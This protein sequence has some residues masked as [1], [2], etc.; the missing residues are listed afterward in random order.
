MHRGASQSNASTKAISE[1][2]FSGKVNPKR[3]AFR[4][5]DVLLVK[6]SLPILLIF[7]L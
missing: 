4:L 2:N 5:G 1:L 7:F 6:L 3:K